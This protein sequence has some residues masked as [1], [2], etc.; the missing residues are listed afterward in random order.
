M[1]IKKLSLLLLTAVLFANNAMVAD[2]APAKTAKKQAAIQSG[3][4]VRAKVEVSGLYDQ[5]CYDAFYGCMDQFCIS[6]NE[7]GGSCACS[8]LNAGY[9][10]ELLKI[11]DILDKAEHIRTVEV[12]KIQAGANA[13]IIFGGTR[14][15]DEDGNILDVDELSAEDKKKQRQADLMAMFEENYEDED[16]DIFGDVGEDIFNKTGNELY[17]AAEKLCYQQIPDK[18]PCR[19]WRGTVASGHKPR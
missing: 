14:Q 3:T 2:A 11:K 5:E 19:P 15:Y 4:K 17:K 8:D 18:C 7:N 9:E 10:K 13:D 6:D 12:E 16:E 1:S